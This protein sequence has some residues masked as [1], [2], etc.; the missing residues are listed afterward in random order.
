MKPL[1]SLILGLLVAFLAFV[2]YGAAYGAVSAKSAEVS[3]LQDQI[4]LRT[5]TVNRLTTARA[6]LAE[7]STDETSVANYFVPQ[8]GIVSF[9]DNLEATGRALGANV[10]TQSVSTGGTSV[11]PTLDLS[12]TADGTFDAVMRTVG[13]I[14]YAP[15][16]ISIT[17]LS[18]GA[19][20]KGSWEAQM[21]LLVG[22]RADATST[23]S[24]TP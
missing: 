12:L 4:N 22:S 1:T 17:R 20:D 24:T 7:L 8:S 5:A 11:R 2:A 10:Q 16:A 19:L 18:V 21:E 9:I 23:P 14:E 15:Y 13:A 6:T 3:A